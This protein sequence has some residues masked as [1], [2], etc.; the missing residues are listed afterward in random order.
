[1]HLLLGKETNVKKTAIDKNKGL[2]INSRM[3]QA[4][5]PERFGNAS[6]AVPDRR[7]QRKLDQAAGLVPFAVK[8]DGELVKKL[9]ALAQSQQIGLNELVTELLTKGLK[10]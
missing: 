8:L 7:E 6:G 1:M 3:K 5:V 10:G 4:G 9:Q 2:N